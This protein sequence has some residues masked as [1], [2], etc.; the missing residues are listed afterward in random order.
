M[1]WVIPAVLL[2]QLVLAGHTFADHKKLTKAEAF[3]VLGHSGKLSRDIL[4]PDQKEVGFWN[5][6]TGENSP[7]PAEDVLVVLHFQR[8]DDSTEWEPIIFKVTDD[9]EKTV[10]EK[11][12]F[13][14]WFDKE[15]R[16]AKAFMLER[17][18]C[19]NLKITVTAGKQVSV[20]KLPF[21]CGL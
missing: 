16:G 6:V 7:E 21:E 14:V 12:N 2:L 13:D 19:R 18:T 15:G 3:L 10:L 5:V 8:L 11:E 20:F 17:A 4:K 9:F 1:R